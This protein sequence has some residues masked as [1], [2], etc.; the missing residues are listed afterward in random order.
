MGIIYRHIS[1]SGKSYVGKTKHDSWEERA[2]ADLFVSYGNCTK[3]YAA[4]LKYGWDNFSHEIL[5]AGITSKEELSKRERYWI[6]YYSSVENGYNIRAG[7]GNFLQSTNENNETVPLSKLIKDYEAGLSLVEVGKKY[8]I[9]FT[10]VYA[11]L[12]DANVKMRTRGAKPSTFKKM[13]RNK[14]CPICKEEFIAK[15]T[16]VIY[17][18][19]ECV[20]VSLRYT[21]RGLEIP[22]KVDKSKFTK[23]SCISEYEF[24]ESFSNAKRGGI[25]RSHIRWHTSL[26]IVNPDCICCQQ[27]MQR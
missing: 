6:S 5:E 27:D 9:P 8:N 19:R 4:I 17:C 25:A 24:P 22:E 12:I 18:S 23:D 2:G 15:K 3:F 26:D 21:N 13:V 11:R 10:I 20:G 14:V 1:P 16:V 7:D